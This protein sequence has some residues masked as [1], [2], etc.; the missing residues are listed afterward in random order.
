MTSRGNHSLLHSTVPP[1]QMS[2]VT[3]TSLENSKPFGS[4]G[5]D[6]DDDDD[7]ILDR[8]ANLQGQDQGQ[9]QGHSRRIPLACLKCRARRARCSGQRPTCAG[10]TKLGCECVYP[11][12]RRRKRTRKEMDEASRGRSGSNS[13]IRSRASAGALQSLSGDSPIEQHLAGIRTN[14]NL[15]HDDLHAL[16][17]SGHTSPR[18]VSFGLE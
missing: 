11:E 16:E 8:N 2:S 15:M 17:M 5:G 6:G 13:E 9:G 1:D 14:T 4:G 7:E 18:L 10:C 12:G 3:T